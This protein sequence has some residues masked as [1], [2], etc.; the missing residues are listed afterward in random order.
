MD[1]DFDIVVKHELLDDKKAQ[2]VIKK[3]A[4]P[5]DKFPRILKTDPQIAKLNP[6]PGQLVAIYRDDPTGKYVYYRVV[7]DE[8]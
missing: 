5:L 7:V 3:L 8:A 1:Y 2:E 6:K 4:T